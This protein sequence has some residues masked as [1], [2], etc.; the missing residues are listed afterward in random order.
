[1]QAI[2]TREALRALYGSPSERAVRKDI[3]RIDKHCRHF[4]SRSPFL[5][6]ATMGPNGADVSPRGDPPGFVR[7]LDERRLIIP[8]RPG[9]KRLDSLENILADPRVGLLFFLPGVDETLRINGRARIVVGPELDGLEVSG[10]A[11]QTA[12]LVEAEEVYLHCAKALIRSKLWDPA[13]RI[14][15]ARFPS[16]GTILA[17][18]LKESDSA[19]ID[20]SLDEAYRTKLY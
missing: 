19:T 16:F 4:I 10:R 6:L 3:G 17:D 7:V 11:P 2:E 8:D 5:V 1:M 15:R 14:E 13:T 9:N 12:L 20:R 18:Q